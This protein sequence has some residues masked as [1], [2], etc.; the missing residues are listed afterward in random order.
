M[1]TEKK[2][3]VDWNAV[4]ALLAEAETEKGNAEKIKALWLK[5]DAMNAATARFAAEGLALYT[6]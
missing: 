2:E 6:V 4:Q 3:V 5:V 1:A